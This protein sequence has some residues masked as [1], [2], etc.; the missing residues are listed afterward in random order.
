MAAHLGNDYGLAL[1]DP[2]I[3]QKAYKSFC[4][5]LAKGKSQKSWF[6][7]EGEHLCCYKTMLSY[8]QNNPKEF[9]PIQREIA[10]TKGY[11]YW[12][13]VVE[14]SAEG[15][16]PT[17]NTA[18][19]QMVMRNKFGWDKEQKTGNT[20]YTIKVNSDGLATGVSTETLPTFDNQGSEF[21]H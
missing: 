21:R 7:E 20:Q 6:F 3:R 2:A 8:I 19:L 15:R 4:D 10:E 16:N 14:A 11:Q 1:K 5:H 17:A 18:S 13:S 12:E 9:P